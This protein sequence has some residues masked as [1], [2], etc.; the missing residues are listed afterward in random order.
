MLDKATEALIEALKIAVADPGEHRLYKSGKLDGLFANRTGANAEAAGRAVREGLLEMVRTESKGKTTVEWVRLAP[1]GADF[2]HEQESPI[3]ALKDLQAILQTTA[4]GVPLWLTEMRQDMQN[5]GSKLA[6]QAERWTQRLQALSERVEE[7]LR[8]VEAG[9]PA[10]PEEATADAPWAKD[11]LAYLDRRQTS[12][13]SEACPMPE[14]F[15][16]IRRQH[17]DLSLSAFHDRLRRLRDRQAVRLLPFTGP[18]GEMPEPEYALVDG[19]TLLY[20]VAR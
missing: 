15:D 14:L 6:E 20:F 10:L 3:Q 13:A 5:L 8:R 4:A 12:G 16:V 11:A 2:L 7:A 9:G 19:A 1:R 17:S 18:P